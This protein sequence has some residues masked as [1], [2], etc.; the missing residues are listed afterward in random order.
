MKFGIVILLLVCLLIS[1]CLPTTQIRY[2]SRRGDISIIKDPGEPLIVDVH[3]DTRDSNL[4]GEI[5]TKKSFAIDARGRYYPLFAKNN[6]YSESLPNFESYYLRRDVWRVSPSGH[7][8][9]GWP[10][11]EWRLHLERIASDGR[12]TYDAHF[13]LWLLIWTPLM[14]P[15]N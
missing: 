9:R 5:D 4:Q 12:E 11:G 10:N 1:G 14:G 3:T 13:K 2:I 15:P 8:I 7:R 6:D